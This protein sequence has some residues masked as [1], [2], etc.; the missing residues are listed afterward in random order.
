MARVIS[1]GWERLP[2]GFDVEFR[3]GVPVRVS[4]NGK[5]TPADAAL[6]GAEIAALGGLRVV[7][8]EWHSGETAGEHEARLVVADDQF[9]AVLERLALAAAELFFDRFH[10]P[11]DASD[12]DWD[13]L[14]YLR[15]FGA[16]L[17]H[18]GLARGTVDE[19]AWRAA[20]LDTM[21]RETRRLALLKEPAQ[22]EP[23]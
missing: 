13:R 19:E 7:P 22:V 2:S 1:N 20:Y 12:V 10:K 18:C 6:L 4:D 14:E 3:H 23:E 17:E 11:V 16:A 8:G 15:D 21:H 5:G 9:A